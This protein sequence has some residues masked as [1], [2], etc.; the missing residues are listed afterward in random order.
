LAALASEGVEFRGVIYFGLMLTAEGPKVIEYNARFGD[1][2]AQAVLPLVESDLLELMIASADGDFGTRELKIKSGG[3]CCVVM[4]SGGYPGSYETG[5]NIYFTD[6]IAEKQ[7]YFTGGNISEVTVFHAG[8]KLRNDG[9]YVTSGGRVLGVT[10]VSDT[11]SKAI[12]DAYAAV[13]TINFDGMHYRK[14]IGIKYR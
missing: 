1:P 6:E 14:D 5:K 7:K 12:E 11:L 13:G 10:A 8:T 3:S 4:A 9:G 2:E